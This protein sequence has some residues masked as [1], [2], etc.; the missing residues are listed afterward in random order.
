MRQDISFPSRMIG[1]IHQKL[2]LVAV[3]ISLIMVGM[4]VVYAFNYDWYYDEVYKWDEAAIVFQQVLNFIL[5]I[6]YLIWLTRVHQAMKLKFRYYPIT[7]IMGLVRMIPFIH[8]WG[9]IDTYMRLSLFFR[10]IPQLEKRGRLVKATLIMMFSLVLIVPSL[11]FFLA[12][13]DPDDVWMPISYMADALLI[14][15]YY[16]MTRLVSSAL[17]LLFVIPEGEE[18][19]YN[20]AYEAALAYNRQYVQDNSRR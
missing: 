18:F 9:I 15:S 13:S 3:I 7:P 16:V 20:P 14:I 1:G 8:L 19:D 5:I 4:N 17:S 2:L 6:T 11:N 12:E 10:K